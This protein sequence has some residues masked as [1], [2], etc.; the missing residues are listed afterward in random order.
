[1]TVMADTK[2]VVIYSSSYCSKHVWIVLTFCGSQKASFW[3]DIVFKCFSFRLNFPFKSKILW[4]SEKYDVYEH[5][6]MVTQ[7]E[8]FLLGLELSKVQATISAPYFWRYC[9]NKHVWKHEPCFRSESKPWFLLAVNTRF[10]GIHTLTSV[11]VSLSSQQLEH[12]GSL[13]KGGLVKGGLCLCRDHC[14]LIEVQGD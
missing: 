2:M 11:L 4:V 6:K 1:M 13:V 12:E 9:C 10:G 8:Y 14:S 5:V 7:E 3:L